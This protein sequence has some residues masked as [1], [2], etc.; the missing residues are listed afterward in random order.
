MKF[1][2][3]LKQILSESKDGNDV[4]TVE[5][6]SP[7]VMTYMDKMSEYGGTKWKKPIEKKFKEIK[8]LGEFF[9]IGVK[10]KPSK[11]FG[12]LKGKQKKYVESAMDKMGIDESDVDYYVEQGVPTFTLK[13]IEG[14]IAEFF[15]TLFEL[16]DMYELGQDEADVIP[17]IAQVFEYIKAND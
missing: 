4:I 2:S 15:V 11:T 5:L 7:L 14:D 9:D 12:K 16:K 17:D 3:K 6:Y 8:E 1:E 13:G 10:S